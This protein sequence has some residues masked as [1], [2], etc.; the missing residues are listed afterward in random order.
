MAPGPLKRKI[1]RDLMKCPFCGAEDTK[2]TDSRDS[3]EAFEIRGG[4]DEEKAVEV[5]NEVARR[6]NNNFTVHNKIPTVDD[7]NTVCVEVLREKGFDRTADK[8]ESYSLDRQRVRKS[9]LTVKKKAGKADITDQMLLVQ[10]ITNETIEEF[11]R[12]KLADALEK[13]YQLSREI[14]R[15]HV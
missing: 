15:A 8:F 4:R 3:A 10:S 1:W 11:D 2:V 9:G 5:A 12:K 14:G 6:L 7:S 13:E